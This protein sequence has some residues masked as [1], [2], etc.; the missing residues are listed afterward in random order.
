VK[1]EIEWNAVKIEKHVRI[2]HPNLSEFRRV[3]STTSFRFDWS[4]WPSNHSNRFPVRNEDSKKCLRPK[5]SNIS[6]YVTLQI[7][8]SDSVL[9]FQSAQGCSRFSFP[10]AASPQCNSRFQWLQY[11]HRPQHVTHAMLK[12]Q[13][14]QHEA[15]NKA[16][17]ERAETNIEQIKTTACWGIPKEHDWGY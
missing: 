8:S 3:L 10:L 12:Q 13:A 7:L 11:Q 14:K 15:W 5:D 16:Y 6:V 9:T 4:C 1:S 17:N 2:L